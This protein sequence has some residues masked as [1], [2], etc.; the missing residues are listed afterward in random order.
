MTT[1]VN[2]TAPN[3]STIRVNTDRIEYIGPSNGSALPGS[4]SVVGVN[5][6]N[7]PVQETVDQILQLCIQE[8]VNVS[9]AI[10]VTPAT[11]TKL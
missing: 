8:E 7:Y 11:A 2:L 5:G 10:S 6:N 1:F 3:G 4:N 9:A